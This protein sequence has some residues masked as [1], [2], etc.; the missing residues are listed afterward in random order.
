VGGATEIQKGREGKGDNNTGNVGG[1]PTK[2]RDNM[3]DSVRR[4]E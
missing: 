2:I 1:I 4:G 3:I